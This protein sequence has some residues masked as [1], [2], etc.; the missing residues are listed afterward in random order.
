[1]VNLKYFSF[2]CAVAIALYGCSNK[3]AEKQEV[4]KTLSRVHLDL[5]SNIAPK[6][7]NKMAMNEAGMITMVNSHAADDF[8]MKLEDCRESL[9]DK[10]RMQGS[11]ESIMNRNRNSEILREGDGGKQYAIFPDQDLDLVQVPGEDG[12]QS[13]NLIY[14]SGVRN[15]ADLVQQAEF[16][17]VRFNQ[18]DYPG[19]LHTVNATINDDKSKNGALEQGFKFKRIEMIQSNTGNSI[20]SM[21]YMGDR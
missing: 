10:N 12:F 3:F 6:I 9:L 16:R 15:G 11:Q 17:N 19:A 21:N 20:H 2:F 14:T 4:S 7:D 8:C 1:M 18:L 5:S 13:V